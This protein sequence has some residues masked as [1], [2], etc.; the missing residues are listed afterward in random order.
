LTGSAV[1][2][3]KSQRQQHYQFLRIRK[4]HFDDTLQS[5]KLSDRGRRIV[6]RNEGTAAAAIPIP[7]V[8]N[9]QIKGPP[10]QHWF[11]SHSGSSI[12]NSYEFESNIVD[13]FRVQKSQAN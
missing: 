2:V 13:T 11:R 3:P 9:L 7:G 8:T 6:S 1:L 4:Q 12:T 5:H 10:Q